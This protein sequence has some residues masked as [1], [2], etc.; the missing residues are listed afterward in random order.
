[1][2]IDFRIKPPIP[3]WEQLYAEG[4][5][6]VTKGFQIPGFTPIQSDTL[7][8][9]IAEQDKLGITHGVIMGRG[10]EPGSSND[11]L[12]AFLAAQQSNR[13]IGFIGADAPTIA[14]S[15]ASIEKYAPLGLFRG[16]SINPAVIQ[17]NVA[18][19]DPSWDPIYEA[20]LK[21]SLPLSITLSVFIGLFG[22][23]INYDYA[24]P[25][26]LIRAARKYP[27]LKII[28]S[29]SG[30]PFVSEAISTAIFCPNIYLSP[31]LYL[32]YPGSSQYVEAA[33]FALSDRLLYG[34]CFPNVPYDFAIDHFR[35][36][37]WKEGVL[38][39][40]LYENGARLLNL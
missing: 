40:V 21:H 13:F 19:E 15:V 3:A 14:E 35:S 6:G 8:E 5:D 30:W 9:V 38:H 26:R 37:N 12:A 18:L 4:R 20:S 22:P 17:P 29:H 25:S 33:N 36:Q 34:S 23:D 27:D 24:R 11:E 1:M 16:V 28:I 2:I 7:E 32:G 10:N 39:K 31:D